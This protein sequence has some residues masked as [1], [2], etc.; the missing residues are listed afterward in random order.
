VGSGGTGRTASR[1]S[2]ASDVIWMS[3]CIITVFLHAPD[4]IRTHGAS[5]ART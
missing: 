2:G 4:A 3:H 1:P 5:A